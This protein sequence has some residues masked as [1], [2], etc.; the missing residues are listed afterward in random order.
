M[1][2]KEFKINEFLSLVLK[3]DKTLIYVNGNKF[4]Q[5]KYVLLNIPVNDIDQYAFI[6]SIDEVIDNL[7]H[8]LEEYTELIP[9]ET[10]FWAHCSNLQA[11]AEN[12]Y[13]TDL[14]V[15]TLSF[16]LLKELTNAGDSK[17]KRVFKEE[18]GKRLMRGELSSIG[19]LIDGGYLRFLT[20]EEIVSIFSSDNCLVFDNIFKIYQKDDLD[21]FSL[22]SS[23]FRDIG[24][25]LF[26]SI[27][28]KLQHIFNTGNVEDLYIFFNY[29]MFDFLTDEEISMLFDSPMDLLERSLNILNNIDCENIKIEE[30]L[31]SE[32]I[33]NVLGEKI[34]ERLLKLIYKKNMKYDVFFY[35]DLLKYL[36]NDDTDYL[37]YLENI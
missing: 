1:R 3:W 23:I 7:D 16:P 12:D 20:C 9:P 25:Y 8:S 33:D 34:Q 5:C 26:S 31:L 2:N 13:N 29:H 22:A 35:L 19:Y 4:R 17:A 37:N 27:E 11:W 18:I 32:K 36:K 6:N 30:G 14:L 21:Q 10:K 24:K 15:L 28:R